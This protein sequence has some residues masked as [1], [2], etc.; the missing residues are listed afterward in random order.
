[1]K[2]DMWSV[3]LT[4]IHISTRAEGF[5]DLNKILLPYTQMPPVTL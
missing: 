5:L 3:L 2:I 4:T 1:M